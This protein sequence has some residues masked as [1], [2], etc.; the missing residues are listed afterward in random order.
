VNEVMEA[1]EYCREIEAYLCRKNEGHLIRIVGPVF[2]RVCGWMAQG[3]PLKVAFR[4][5]DQY[6]ER[7]DAKG[8]RRRP[9]RVEFCEADILDNFDAWRRAV[10]VE[11]PE[12]PAAATGGRRPSLASHLERVIARLTAARAGRRR[13]EAFDAAVAT[14]VRE[15]D[16]L[17]AASRHAR[18]SARDRILERLA[19]I[20]RQLAGAAS[21]ELDPA[22]LES[23]QRAAAAELAPFA[24]RMSQDELMKSIAAAFDRLLRDELELPI[25]TYDG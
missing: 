12:D 7:Y 18:G 22:V 2:E 24:A 5:I 9:V 3:V 17:A 19:E 14:A 1:A 20:D 15:L 16:G 11:A 25:A 23:L 6:C 8:P 21:G 10:G 4:G 13:S